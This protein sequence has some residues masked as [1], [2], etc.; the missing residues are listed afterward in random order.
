[1]VKTQVHQAIDR[2][3]QI[4]PR[5]CA[6]I[7]PVAKELVTKTKAWPAYMAYLRKLWNH[8]ALLGCR[9]I[10]SVQVA[11]TLGRLRCHCNHRHHG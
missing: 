2:V 4:D 6:F 1:M 8:W 9:S 3:T 5:N 11:Q 7:Q 10:C